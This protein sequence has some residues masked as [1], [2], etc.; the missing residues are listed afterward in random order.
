MS[1][2]TQ[3]ETSQDRFVL[4]VEGPLIKIIDTTREDGGKPWVSGTFGGPDRLLAATE[5]VRS[6]NDRERLRTHPAPPWPIVPVA[7][8]DGY[9]VSDRIAGLSDFSISIGGRDVTDM[10]NAV[11]VET[12]RGKLWISGTRRERLESALAEAKRIEDRAVELLR[13]DSEILSRATRVRTKLEQQ[14]VT[15]LSEGEDSPPARPPA[16]Q[17]A[18]TG[19]GVGGDTLGNSEAGESRSAGFPLIEPIGEPVYT[20]I[21]MFKPGPY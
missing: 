7:A 6:L 11:S 15:L 20:V 13:Q 21:D 2:E 12:P 14:L 17:G 18:E 3:D 10:V 16:A 8:R 5:H 1:E 4:E 19:S 9:W